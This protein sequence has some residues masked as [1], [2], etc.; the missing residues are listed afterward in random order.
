MDIEYDD[1]KLNT[2]VLS[3]ELINIIHLND[4][5]I[6]EL[7]ESPSTGYCWFY[8][9]SD[10]SIVSLEEK[11]IYDF[12]RPNIIGGT[13]KIIWKFKGI[14]AGECKIYFS[15]YKSWKKESFPL[16]EYIYIIKV[17]K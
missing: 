11:K 6:I 15:Y 16:D 4:N 13:I 8:T 14:S 12:N 9:V 1:F 7:T 2:N 3:H 5:M 10:P 17:E